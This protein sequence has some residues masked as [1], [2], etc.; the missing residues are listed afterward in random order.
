MA[1][2]K[3]SYVFRQSSVTSIWLNHRNSNQIKCTV[4]SLSLKLYNM[5]AIFFFFNH[6]TEGISSIFIITEV[7]YIYCNAYPNI[8]EDHKL[9]KI[10]TGS[11]PPHHQRSTVLNFE[12]LKSTTIY[13]FS[14]YNYETNG[15]V[16]GAKLH[17]LMF[18]L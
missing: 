18:E 12:T 15:N 16:Q 17:S 5:T 7:A 11:P 3:M 2:D 4:I 6:N 10:K 14:E 13:L 8:V 1:L 9:I